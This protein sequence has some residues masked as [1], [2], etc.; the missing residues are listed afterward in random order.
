MQEPEFVELFEK[1]AQDVTGEGSSQKDMIDEMMGEFTS[2][3]RDNEG[4]QE[5]KRE[6]DKMMA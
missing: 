4:N 6:F 2:F 1:F 5:L 3:M